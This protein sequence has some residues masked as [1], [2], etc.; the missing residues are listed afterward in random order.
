MNRGGGQGP[1][2]FSSPPPSSLSLSLSL[3][4]FSFPFSLSLLL[5]PF[6]SVFLSLALVLLLPF[7][8]SLLFLLSFPLLPCLLPAVEREGGREIG[9][10]R[11]RGMKRATKTR[12][13]KMM[14]ARPLACPE[15]SAPF[16]PFLRREQGE[17]KMK[18]ATEEKARE[19]G[20]GGVHP[21]SPHRLPPS[22][23]FLSVLCYSSLFAEMERR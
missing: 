8:D 2:A 6:L 4:L 21:S 16:I 3:S 1:A 20:E 19:P 22:C 7:S 15:L 17:K 18:K 5:A 9:R 11:E 23:L 12:K 13:E 10:E 14:R